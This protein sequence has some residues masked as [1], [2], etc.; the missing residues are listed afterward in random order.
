MTIKLNTI[1]DVN[2][3]VNI[4]IRYAPSDIDIKQDRQVIKGTSILWIFSL[5]LLKPLKVVF[6][7]KNDNKKNLFYNNIKKWEIKKG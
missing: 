7:D 5:N 1:E 2:R 6:V 4:C 3:F